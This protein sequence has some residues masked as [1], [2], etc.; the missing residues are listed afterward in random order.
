MGLH[1]RALLRLR[2]LGA[3][4]QL[5]LLQLLQVELGGR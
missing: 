5:L 4:L 1:L 3:L 2:Q